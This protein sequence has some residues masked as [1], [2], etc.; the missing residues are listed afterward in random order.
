MGSISNAFG[1]IQAIVGSDNEGATFSRIVR[2]SGVPKSSA[3][4]ILR[5]L[6]DIGALRYDESTRTYSGGLLLP[7]L[8]SAVMSK[9][10]IR[11]RARPHLIRLHE[12]TGHTVTLGIQ[13]GERGV[14]V[15]RIEHREFGVRLHSEIGKSFPLHCTGIGKIMLAWSSPQ[16]RKLALAG[17]LE[18]YTK[19]T[20]TNKQDLIRS[21]ELI[22]ERGYAIDDEE[23][24]RGFVCIAAPVF[25][26]DGQ[27]AGALSC[28]LPTYMRD[29]HGIDKEIELVVKTAADASR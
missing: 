4:R 3:H 8:G 6:T 15:D 26:P 24:T 7:R 21:L 5:E 27:L 19:N 29:E 18:S 17:K 2:D 9:Y 14:Y 1:M 12:A 11:D 25:G 22:R 20:I 23:I 16:E 13:D 10:D 28:T